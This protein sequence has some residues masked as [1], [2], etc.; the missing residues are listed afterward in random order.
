MDKALGIIGTFFLV[1]LFLILFL[2]AM[3]ILICISHPKII[4]KYKDKLEIKAKLWFF[5][6]NLTRFLSRKKKDKK[7]KV[8]HFDG[9]LFGEL[10]EDKKKGKK[11]KS[12]KS[13]AQHTLSGKREKSAGGVSE[14]SPE[15]KEKKPLTETVSDALELVT[16]ILDDVKEPLKKVLKADIRKLYITAASDDPHKTALLFGRLNTAMG[17]LIFVCKKYAS[18]SIDESKAGIYSD[19]LAAKPGIDA[20]IVLTL[21]FRHIVICGVKG[22]KRFF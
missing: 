11:K 16:D 12:G 20:H 4:I 22:I 17:V 3:L 6:F 7:P 8:I 21:S 14:A 10:P 5:G 1:L 13:S 15:E 19:F 9:G 18:L 2:L